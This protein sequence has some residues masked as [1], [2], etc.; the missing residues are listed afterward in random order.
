MEFPSWLGYVEYIAQVR[1][2]RLQFLNLFF[3]HSAKMDYKYEFT[4]I[5]NGLEPYHCRGAFKGVSNKFKGCFKEITKVFQGSLQVVSR[6]IEW[7][8]LTL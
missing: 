7:Y 8:S 1:Y 3:P 6:N 5:T 2:I 4:K